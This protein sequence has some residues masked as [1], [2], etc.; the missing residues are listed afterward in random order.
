MN[1]TCSY[2]CFPCNITPLELIF[3]VLNKLSSSHLWFTL[4][5]LQ[6][7]QTLNSLLLKGSA[8]LWPS[9]ENA[10]KPQEAEIPGPGW[11]G[12]PANHPE[13]ATGSGETSESP[14]QL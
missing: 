13:M 8:S 2:A 9:T 11:N 4:A 10:M 3:N 7:L 12:E 1:Q 5:F 14:L 6:T